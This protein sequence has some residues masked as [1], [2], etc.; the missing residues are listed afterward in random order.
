[1]SKKSNKQVAAVVNLARHTAAV[2]RENASLRQQIATRAT[3]PPSAPVPAAPTHVVEEA[4]PETPFHQVDRAIL[5]EE[6]SRAFGGGTRG[7]F[8]ANVM[9]ARRAQAGVRAR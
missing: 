3:P 9:L 8:M 6:T 4:E 2:E 7:E 5:H 1:M